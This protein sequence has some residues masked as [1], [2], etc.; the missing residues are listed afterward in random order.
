V[1]VAAAA[2]PQAPLLIPGLTGGS[3]AEVEHVRDAVR[4]AVDIIARHHPDEVVVVGAAPA[5]TTYPPG[6]S[7]PAGRLAPAPGRQPRPTA[8]PVPLAVG[9][10]ALAAHSVPR[11]LQGIEHRARVDLCVR[12]GR[13]IAARPGR[14][15]LLA[16]AD[17]SARRGKKAPGYLDPRAKDLDACITAALDAA[18]PGALLAL[19]P[20]LCEDLLVAGRAA[21]QVMAGACDGTSWLGQTLYS[22]DPFG[23]Q[24]TVVTW[25]RARPDMRRRESR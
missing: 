5:T 1:I 21:W 18:D 15:A 20:P 11:S 24:Y 23:V 4:D 13:Q 8:L 6:A 10:S 22:A 7:S 19:D 3:I 12:L 14:T 17:G 9:R 2:I 16:V 25:T